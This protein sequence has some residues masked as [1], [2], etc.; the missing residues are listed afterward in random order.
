MRLGIVIGTVTLNRWHES[1]AGGKWRLVTPLSWA[2]LSRLPQGE[3][4][5]LQAFASDLATEPL[6]AY[7]EIHAGVGSLVAF[8]E[9]REASSPFHPDVKPVDAYVTA[10]LDQLN[11]TKFE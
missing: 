7:D 4:D 5:N 8:T 1:L 10:I 11:V 2:D 6:T 9:G 3:T